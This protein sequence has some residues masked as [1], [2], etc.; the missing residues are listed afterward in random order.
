MLKR[1]CGCTCK[2]CDIAVAC[3]IHNRRDLIRHASGFVF[4]D[5]VLY[6]V[7]VFCD[8]DGI[9][10]VEYVNTAVGKQLFRK[11]GEK[12][13]IVLYLKALV[14]IGFGADTVKPVFGI[15][16]LGAV[17]DRKPQKLLGDTEG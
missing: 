11:Y 4:G 8:S 12:L 6:L 16:V 9:R 1:V 10:A 3:R 5:D 17:L 14:L 15:S 7:D 13:G 2:I